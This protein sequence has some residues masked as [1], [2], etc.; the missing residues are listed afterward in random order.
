N[1]RLEGEPDLDAKVSLVREAVALYPGEPHFERLLKLMEDKRD[2]VRS[3]VLR[4]ETHEERGQINEA[5]SDYE[6]L[7]S[8]YPLYTGLKYEIERL[9]KRREQLSRDAAKADWVRQVD[10]Q[11]ENGNYA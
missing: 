7:K 5:L 10:R 4:A 3:I 9:Q 1:R 6:T 8:I 2:L 11:L